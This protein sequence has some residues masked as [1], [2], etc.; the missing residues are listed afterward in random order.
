MSEAV[1]GEFRTAVSGRRRESGLSI[2]ATPEPPVVQITPRMRDVLQEL[3]TDGATNRVI[4]R[5]LELS[6]DSVKTHLCRLYRAFGVKD[7]TQLVVW[8]LTRKVRI[9]LVRERGK[10]N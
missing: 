4:A 10:V 8:V 3:I 5:R 1:S 6:L 9:E 2:V 7:R